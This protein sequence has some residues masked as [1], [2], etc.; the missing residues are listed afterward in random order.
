MKRK[1]KK[2]GKTIGSLKPML[3]AYKGQALRVLKK[4]TNQQRIK[5]SSI[6]PK[7][8]DSLSAPIKKTAFFLLF[9]FSKFYVGSE[10]RQKKLNF[11]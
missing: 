6:F 9:S 7:N 10:A 4:I 11:N 5:S 3:L 1:T 2:E 8:L